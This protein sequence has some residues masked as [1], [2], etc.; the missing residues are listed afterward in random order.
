[1]ESERLKNKIKVVKIK[2][3]QLKTNF[4]KDMNEL[5]RFTMLDERS[6]TEQA[7]LASADV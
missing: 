7:L 2:Q 1:M 5:K 6:G 4:E 3:S